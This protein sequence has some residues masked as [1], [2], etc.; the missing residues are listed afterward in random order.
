MYAEKKYFLEFQKNWHLAETCYL[1]LGV[2]LSALK[3]CVVMVGWGGGLHSI[4]WHYFEVTLKVRKW[5]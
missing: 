3:V 2:W 5:P 1:Y 4:M